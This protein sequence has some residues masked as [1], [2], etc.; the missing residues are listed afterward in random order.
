MLMS[1]S[2]TTQYPDEVARFI[3]FLFTKDGAIKALGIER[4]I[5]GSAR[6]QA[7]LKPSLKPSDII[8]LNLVQ[9]ITATARPKLVL[10]LP[11]AGEVQ[12]LLTLTAQGLSFGKLTVAQAADTFVTQTD[13]A[14]ERVG[15]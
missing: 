6:A 12:D 5:P 11:G 8:Q 3:N 13:Q 14:L 15:V 2:A 4:G 7:L 1:A 10:D 9:L